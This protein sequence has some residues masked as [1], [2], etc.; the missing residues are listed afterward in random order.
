MCAVLR[1]GERR[2]GGFRSR[3]HS[4]VVFGRSIGLEPVSPTADRLRE[5]TQ[6]LSTDS[7]GLRSVSPNPVSPNPV[8]S[9]PVPPNP[10]S[11]ND[12]L[13]RCK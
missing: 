10:V 6:A 12:I 3:G 7:I 1:S 4:C 11:P 9:N 13:S 8:S 5:K 2:E